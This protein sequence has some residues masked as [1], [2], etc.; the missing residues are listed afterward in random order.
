MGSGMSRSQAEKDMFLR[1]MLW[2]IGS[3]HP[4]E[5]VGPPTTREEALSLLDLSAAQLESVAQVKALEAGR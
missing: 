4:D 2:A 3:W 5:L 1:N